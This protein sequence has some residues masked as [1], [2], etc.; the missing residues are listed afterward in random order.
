MGQLRLHTRWLSAIR[1]AGVNMET[2]H[3]LLAPQLQSQATMPFV[4][5]SLCQHPT[6]PSTSSQSSR[7]RKGTDSVRRTSK[8][9]RAHCRCTLPPLKSDFGAFATGAAA[10]CGNRCFETRFRGRV[11]CALPARICS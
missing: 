2:L 6:M 3:A 7:K 5:S 4:G 10:W 11:C 8:H 1:R 9:T